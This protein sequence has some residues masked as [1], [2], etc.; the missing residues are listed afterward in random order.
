MSF[1]SF[2]PSELNESLSGRL[3]DYY[4]HKLIQRPDLHDKVEFEIVW[5]CFTFDLQ[6]KKLD[7]LP[8]E[9][10]SWSDKQ[11]LLECLRNVTNS[12]LHP[13]NGLWLT[14]AEN[15]NTRAASYEN[16]RI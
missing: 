16:Q 12:V 10:F 11:E 13:V 6:K 7:S 14:D 5:S 8:K 9:K 2:I 3:V 4:I 15:K 1:N